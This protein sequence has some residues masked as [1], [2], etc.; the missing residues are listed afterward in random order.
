MAPIPPMVLL[1]LAV[2]LV[3]VA[4]PMGIVEEQLIIVLLETVSHNLVCARSFQGR[5]KYHV[6]LSRLPK[7]VPGAKIGIRDYLYGVI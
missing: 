6:L 1:V 4:R 5:T 3:T 7:L 2:S